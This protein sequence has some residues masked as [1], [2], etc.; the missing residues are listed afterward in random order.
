MI[1][2]VGIPVDL[3]MESVTIGWVQ[4]SEFFLPENASNFLD[5]L[6]DPFDLT[7]RPITGFFV[8]KKR[9]D[10]LE[11]PMPTENP[12]NVLTEMEKGFDSEQN[13]MFEKHQVE[14]EVV[15][16]ETEDDYHDNEMSEAD[17]WNQ[18]DRAEWLNKIRPNKPKNLAL[19]RWAIY[20]SMA[21]LAER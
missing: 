2:G 7:T 14:A 1:V 20:K 9:S 4:K 18:E 11:E 16:S 13:E 15:E 21:V 6:N 19:A 5:F 3:E 10:L 8:R 12:A 17:Y